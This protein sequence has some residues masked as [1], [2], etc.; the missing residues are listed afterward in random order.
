MKLK[1][2]NIENDMDIRVKALILEIQ[3]SRDEYKLQLDKYKNDFEKYL[4]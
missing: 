2:E 3:N 4:N 1:I